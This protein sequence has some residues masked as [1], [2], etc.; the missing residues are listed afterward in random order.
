MLA[1]TRI[2]SRGHTLYP[3]Q[4]VEVRPDRRLSD[5]N[6]A[7]YHRVL[8]MLLAS[9][10][11]LP[12]TDLVRAAG[13]TRKPSDNSYR[14]VDSLDRHAESCGYMIYEDDSSFFLV[15]GILG[16]HDKE[17]NNAD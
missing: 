5:E 1:A 11:P 10:T 9:P 12:V 4:E 8:E 2:T 3:Q 15:V 6:E 17:T 13:L 14:L 16:V 7:K